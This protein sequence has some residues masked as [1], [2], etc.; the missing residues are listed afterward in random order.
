MFTDTTGRLQ[1]I[2]A[3]VFSALLSVAAFLLAG[4]SAAAVAGDHVLRFEAVFRPLLA[5]LLLGIFSWMLSF[6]NHVEEHRIAA[7][8][9]PLSAGWARQFGIGCAV[10]FLL[11]IVAVVPIGIWGSMSFRPTLNLRQ[12]V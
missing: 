7:Q 9:L 6:G 1:P 5:V 2:W 10:G 8:G 12:R 4:Y 11:V 3:F